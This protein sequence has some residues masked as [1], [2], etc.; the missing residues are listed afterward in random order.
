MPDRG[1]NLVCIEARIGLIMCLLAGPGSAVEVETQRTG[2]KRTE[3][4]GDDGALRDR[5]GAR[6]A[7]TD[8]LP[9]GGTTQ[10]VGEQPR[11]ANESSSS[12]AL[13]GLDLHGA[14]EPG[15]YGVGF[16]KE[17]L[18][19]GGDR[20][21]DSLA[22]SEL[23]S[24]VDLYLWY[25]AASNGDAPQP[26]T[27]ADYYRCQE[28]IEPDREALRDWLH[29]DMTDAPG[30]DPATL[31]DVL[32]TPMWS[33]RDATA[34]DGRH[35]LVLWSYRDSVPTSQ[36]ALNEYL[37]SH[38]YVVA[39]AWPT[40]RLPP[41]P[42][43]EGTT[44]EEKVDALAIQVRL[45]GMVLDRLSKRPWIDADPVSLLSWSYGGES[46]GALQRERQDV[47]LVVAIDATLAS[48]WVYAPKETIETLEPDTLS[49]PYVVLRNG[50]PRIGGDRSAPPPEFLA[51]ISA[52]AWHVRFPELSHGNFN[53]PGG[54]IPGV[55]GL[56]EV[57]RW[58]VGGEIAR[59][60]YERISRSVLAFLE[61]H[62]TGD[63]KTL[64]ELFPA[65]GPVETERYPPH[66]SQ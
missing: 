61:H 30:V 7:H 54:M 31:D 27:L 56:D 32:D 25:P 59:Q 41:F 37:A 6:T 16:R 36:T 35:P 58:A 5:D 34:A 50:R 23:P 39:F 21:T 52:G 44:A 20:S 46:A 18:P 11:D 64:S 2:S 9:D 17:T 57:S 22:E 8:G 66:E 65:K 43:Q 49:A 19:L 10:R 13:P 38:G 4:Y 42:W 51:K 29:S 47:G 63:E 33:R 62:R 14:L 26:M 53:F 45:L 60:G 40:D 1:R 55:L 12:A 24:A 28:A 3:H 15:R 48:G